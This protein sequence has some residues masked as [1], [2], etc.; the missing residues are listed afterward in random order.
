MDWLN[1]YAEVIYGGR[2]ENRLTPVNRSAK[3][4]DGIGSGR[5]NKMMLQAAIKE[6]PSVLKN[7]II[8]RY[9]KRMPLKETLK[10]L[11]I[12]KDKYYKRCDWAIDYI[13]YSVNSNTN[14]KSALLLK[15]NKSMYKMKSREVLK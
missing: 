12:P 2:Y 5:L 14:G 1:N 11:G 7:V 6:L 15:I 8:A 4:Y 13:Y 10:L 9:I 3:P